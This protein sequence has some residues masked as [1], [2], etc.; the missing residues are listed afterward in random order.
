MVLVY[1]G[2]IGAVAGLLAYAFLR[3]RGEAGYNLVGEIMLGT[4]GALSLAMSMGVMFGWGQMFTRS[5]TV[6]D[7]IASG[8]TAAFGAL[9][10][11][12]LVVYLTLRSSPIQHK[13]RRPE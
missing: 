4:L 8:I 7:I 11:L 12:A 3:L 10:V 5:G 13:D 2:G 6:D 1:W 9:I